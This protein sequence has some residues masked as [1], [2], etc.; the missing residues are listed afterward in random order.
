MNP[1]YTS[2][3]SEQGLIFSGKDDKGERMEC[4]ELSEK[5]HPFFFGCQYHP[6]FQSRPFRPSPPFYGFVAAS[7]GKW[8][9]KER[10]ESGAGEVRRGRGRKNGG[11]GEVNG[12]SSGSASGTDSQENSP[13]EMVEKKEARNGA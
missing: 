2:V 6:E 10:E 11:V 7:A 4:I 12:V 9:R 3:L 8:V 13:K 5:D 1:E